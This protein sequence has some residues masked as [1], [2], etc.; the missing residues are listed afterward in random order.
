MARRTSRAVLLGAWLMAVALNAVTHGIGWQAYSASLD[1]APAFSLAFIVRSPSSLTGETILA[2]WGPVGGMQCF[3]ARRAGNEIEI[4]VFGT[5]GYRGRIT[6]NSP[7]SVSTEIRGVCRWTAAGVMAI[8][9]NGVDCP[10]ATA[11]GFND[12]VTALQA[13]VTSV[14]TAGQGNAYA[15]SAFLG[16]YAEL[17][18]WNV[19]IGATAALAITDPTAPES[20]VT[21]DTNLFFYAPLCRRSEGFPVPDPYLANLIGPDDPTY[22]VDEHPDGTASHP[23]VV[24]PSGSPYAADFCE[25]TAP[26]VA[27]CSGGTVPSV[28]DP[29]DG[30]TFTGLG[31]HGDRVFLEVDFDDATRS[32]AL[33]DPINASP[34][35]AAHGGRK[36]GRLTAIGSIIRRSTD[37][38]GGWQASTCRWSS[39]DHDRV[40]RALQK[41]QRWYGRE[42]RVYVGDRLDLA[43]SRCLGRFNVREHPP[44]QDFGVD[45]EGTDVIGSE[46]SA[47]NLDRDILDSYVFDAARFPEAPRELLDQQPLKPVPVYMGRW[48][49]EAS[50][51]GPPVL[52]GSAARGALLND[53]VW[54][55][56][57]GDMPQPS[58]APPATITPTA[59]GSGGT[60]PVDSYRVIVWGV[61]GG[62]EGD[63]LPFDYQG[64]PVAV[65]S[66]GSSIEVDWTFG[67]TD[68]DFWRIGFAEFYF[69]ARWGAGHVLEVP[70]TARTVT[71]TSYD[72]I[73]PGAISGYWNRREYRVCALMADGRTAPSPVCVSTTGPYARPV[74]VSWLPVTGA[75]AYEVYGTQAVFPKY[76]DFNR[77]WD[78]PTDALDS[79]G[80]VYLDDDWLDTGVTFVAGL[81]APQGMLPVVDTGDVM[82]DGRLCGQLVLCR[83]PVHQVI[84]VYAGETRLS[85][86]HPDVRH[87]D[88]PS[89]SEPNRFVSIAGWDTTVIYVRVGSSLLT[90]HRDRTALIQ[91]NACTTEHLGNG[92][93]ATISNAARIDQ[94]LFTELVFNDH[95]AGLWAGIPLYAD[96]VPILRSSSWLNAETQQIARVG[97]EGYTGRVALIEPTTLRTLIEGAVQSWGLHR[98]IN[99]HGQVVVGHYDDA[100]DTTATYEAF[101]DVRR[102][103]G[104]IRVDPRTRELENSLPYAW[105]FRP[106]LNA[107]DVTDAVLEDATSIAAYLGKPKRGQ[108]RTLPYAGDAITVADVMQRA[109]LLGKYV[110]EWGDVPVAID[111]LGVDLFS[112]IEVTDEEGTGAEGYQGE[113]L[114]VLEVED[115]P[116]DPSQDRPLTR[117]LRG[118]NVTPLFEGAGVLGPDDLPTFLSA[119]EVQ[120]AKYVYAS[121]DDGLMSDGSLAK[122]VR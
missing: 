53:G 47:F 121:D 15:N 54:Q 83:W 37:R 39:D 60:I 30:V 4:Y 122:R 36:D 73:T 105:D 45:V 63:P 92:L 17:A 46:F 67:G 102:I 93:G 14:V 38:L 106:V 111:A 49:D 21:Y 34:L 31:P 96:G 51:A 82:F 5:G 86:S 16:D 41:A 118:L 72:P 11:G 101:T 25:V 48:S 87:P 42:F 103:V 89:W 94:H 35:L 58:P 1:G 80:Y 33:H 77:R 64:E 116:P 70:G 20:P 29:A 55:M 84:S 28:A 69:S 91:V 52:I 81:P 2:K 22:T 97:G 40:L 88:H 32:Y 19:D 98:G 6:T 57:R 65:T 104:H 79:D 26:V 117:V 76:A 18:L 120:Q 109:L 61:T 85:D 71:F 112:V 43:N 13:T 119:S 108:S 44:T 68:P 78:V 9:V 110:R 107:F 50:S 24:Y 12:A 114:L 95:K 66:D 27:S 99:R 3:S 59:I 10:V 74:H 75:L 23:Y 62:V 100:I 113:F 8:C 7:V 90:K 56:G 115:I